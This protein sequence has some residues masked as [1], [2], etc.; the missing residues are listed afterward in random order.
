MDNL[1]PFDLE[2]YKAGAIAVDRN[3]NKYRFV[4]VCLDARK[5]YQLISLDENMIPITNSLDGKYSDIPGFDIIGLLP[6]KKTAWVGKDA[7][8]QHFPDCDKNGCIKVEYEE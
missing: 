3:G 4:A 6:Q 2:K 7:L 8:H 5:N 1:K